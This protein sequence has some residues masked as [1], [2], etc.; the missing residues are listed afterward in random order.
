MQF[1]YY[2]KVRGQGRPRFTRNGRAY[3]AKADRDNKAAIRAAYV[4]AGGGMHEGAVRVAIRTFRTLPK[5]TP[6]RVESAPDT[7]TPDLDNIAKAVLDALSGVAFADD[8]YV[9]ELL[10]EK[11]PRTRTEERMEITVEQARGGEQ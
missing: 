9:V 10:V 6:K 5:N 11:T 1:T 8:S 2:G 4:E 3:E 7:I